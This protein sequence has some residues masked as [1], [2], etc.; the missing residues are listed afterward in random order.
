MRV[1]SKPVDVEAYII[2][3]DHRY[4]LLRQ[5]GVGRCRLPISANKGD[6]RSY[7]RRS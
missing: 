2:K 3:Y 1:G 7:R 5:L 6:Q 4:R